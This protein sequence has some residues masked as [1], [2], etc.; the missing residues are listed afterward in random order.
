MITLTLGKCPKPWKFLAAPA[1]VLLGLTTSSLSAN[2]APAGANPTA[3]TSS[4]TS[5]PDKSGFTLFNPTP[6]VL[7]REFN[8]NRPSVTEG[9][10]TIDAGH[11][12]VELSFA[13]YSQESDSGVR[14][15]AL[16]IVPANIR[17]GVL[18]NVEF[19]LMFNPYLN[20]LV[21]GPT[22]SKRRSGF[23]DITLRESL[24]LWG[25]DGGDT[26]GGILTFVRAPA[27][28]SGFSN[29]HIEGGIILPLAVKLPAGFGLG[30]MIECDIDRNSA[31]DGY[32][33]DLLHTVTIGHDLLEHLTAY[34]EYAGISPISTGNTY[35]AYFDTGVTYALTDNLQLDVGINIG[36]SSRTYDY[37]VF[38]GMS[39]RL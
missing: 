25:N 2:D 1:C 24:N 18:N 31:N 20:T 19:D 12:Q 21:H 4:P 11:V 9:P 5:E 35:V 3:A 38:A 36:L 13:E 14:T 16:S 30:T 10:Y 17:L 7:M 15:D 33:V 29:H 23:G 6:P 39:F 27:G 32:G 37:L 28:T 34:V 22:R 26:A 8:P